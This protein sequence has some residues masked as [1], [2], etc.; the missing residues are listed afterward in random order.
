MALVLC[1]WVLWSE[2]AVH[3]KALSYPPRWSPIQTF[4]DLQDC[5]KVAVAKAKTVGRTDESTYG[6]SG[7]S[8]IA[9]LSSR[10]S[11]DTTFILRYVCLPDTVK[12]GGER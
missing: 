10:S 12:P 9:V 3:T 8:N 6:A 1:A 4:Q 2:E 11:P 7:D 5:E